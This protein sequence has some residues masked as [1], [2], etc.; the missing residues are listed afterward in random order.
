MFMASPHSREAAS[1]LNPLFEVLG[2]GAVVIAEEDTVGLKPCLLEERADF[3]P[4]LIFLRHVTPLICVYRSGIGVLALDVIVQHLNSEFF[5]TPAGEHPSAEAI[6]AVV[7]TE[8]LYDVVP[9]GFADVP[10]HLLEAIEARGWAGKLAAQGFCERLR[11][12]L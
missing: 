2:I 4:P 12:H 6:G 1:L 7:I 3:L 10:T 11:V 9:I 8:A 5:E